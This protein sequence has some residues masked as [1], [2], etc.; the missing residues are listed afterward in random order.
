MLKA[1]D[2]P[3]VDVIHT[4]SHHEFR[5]SELYSL[6]N[7]YGTLKPC[8]TLDFYVNFG[9]DQPNAADFTAAGSHL[10]AIELF[11]W[12]IENFGELRSQFVLNGTPEIDKPVT[13]MKRV[14]MPAEMGYHADPKQTGAS[15][16]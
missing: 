11:L 14:V 4:D 16:H 13:K 5:G 8:G 10:R 2:C 1:S 3:F 9:Y 12:S 15:A 7:K 6:I